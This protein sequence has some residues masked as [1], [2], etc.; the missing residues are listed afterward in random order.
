MV[1]QQRCEA[2]VRSKE[3]R[4]KGVRRSSKGQQRKSGS[5]ERRVSAAPL[6]FLTNR[7][8][9]S[10]VPSAARLLLRNI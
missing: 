9:A 3:L 4:S 5:I 2:K 10:L 1:A 6:T 8:L 7:F